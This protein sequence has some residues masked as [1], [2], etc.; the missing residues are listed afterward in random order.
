MSQTSP[1]LLTASS[2]SMLVLLY[3]DTNYVMEGLRASYF[4]SACPNNCSAHGTCSSQGGRWGCDCSPGWSGPDCSLPLCPGHCGASAG[5]GDCLLTGGSYK[6]HCNKGFVGDDCSLNIK[7]GPVIRTEL[8]TSLHLRTTWVT[9]GPW[10]PGRDLPGSHR[11]LCTLLLTTRP[12]IFFTFTEALTST[13][14]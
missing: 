3:S 10:C 2:G 7:V 6:C 8:N 1:A 13:W 5:W 14:C 9:P 12:R 4:S 11:G